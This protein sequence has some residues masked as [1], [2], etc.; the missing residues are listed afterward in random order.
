MGLRILAN[1][2]ERRLRFELGQ[3]Y[4]V[5]LVALPLDGSVSH[6]FLFASCEPGQAVTVRNEFTAV[7][8]RFLADGP[9]P[10][11]LELDIDA[12]TRSFDRRDAIPELLDRTARD[13]LAGRETHPP[14]ARLARLREVT[15]AGCREA[16]AAA[17]ETAILA[18]PVNKSAGVPWRAY[19]LTSSHVVKGRRYRSATGRFPWSTD[20][21]LFVG[22]EGVSIVDKERRP[23]TIRYTDCVLAF[24]HPYE[25]TI[26]G[27][28]GW[29]LTIRRSE[30]WGAV[31]AMTRI[32]A[33]IP[34]DVVLPVPSS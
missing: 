20:R 8:D 18:G 30:W 16:C 26:F 6:A 10:S 23:I 11:E 9:T 32:R 28:D 22:D 14:A 25:L 13:I 3:S 24:E 2:L 29:A 17:F 7:I 15:P 12:F 33:A 31:D 5:G 21:T 34:P 19:P 4:T 27:R 1:R